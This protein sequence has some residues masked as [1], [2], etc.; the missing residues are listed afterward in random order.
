MDWRWTLL[1]SFFEWWQRYDSIEN[2]KR[3]INENVR[4]FMEL[5]HQQW[6]TIMWMPYKFFMDSLKWKIDLEDEKRRVVEGSAKGRS[7]KGFEK[8]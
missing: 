6:D 1:S 3:T 8:G 5:M 4:S 2:F 7:S